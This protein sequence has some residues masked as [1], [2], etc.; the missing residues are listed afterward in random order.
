MVSEAQSE[1]A[2]ETLQ[3][4]LQRIH[5]AN[6]SAGAYTFLVSHAWTDGPDIFIVYA[7]PP[8]NLTWGL[9]RD[10][11][12][13]IVD[14]QSWTDVAE[15]SLYY[16]LLDFEEN[17]PG[18]FSREPGESDEIRWMGDPR[19]G[20]PSEVAALPNEWRVVAPGDG[21]PRPLLDKRA[22]EPR[23]YVDPQ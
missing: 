1:F 17:W 20:L 9:V 23:R 6:E 12:E 21:Q 15:A 19:E 4:L 5:S 2:A 3:A 11:R 8:S 22:T 13:S 7:A 10:T 16:Y 14:G 18:N